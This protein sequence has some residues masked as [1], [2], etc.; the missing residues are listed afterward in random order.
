MCSMLRAPHR[1]LLSDVSATSS[2]PQLDTEPDPRLYF[3]EIIEKLNEICEDKEQRSK[4]ETER[5]REKE[6][7]GW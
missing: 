6:I 1:K 5:D 7:D 2:L 3:T 4:T